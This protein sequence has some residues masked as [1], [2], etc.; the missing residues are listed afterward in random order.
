MDVF[1]HMHS[2]TLFPSICCTA[3]LPSVPPV[4]P[5]CFGVDADGSGWC[6]VLAD[7]LNNQNEVLKILSI[8]EDG[9][10]I[11]TRQLIQFNHYGEEYQAEV[12]LLSRR[13]LFTTD[14]A[15]L[16]G[17]GSI[18]KTVTKNTPLPVAICIVL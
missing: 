18:G 9:R 15:S 4:R 16:D 8:S 5:A 1:G 3:A 17:P 6:L 10:T 11:R 13:I 12:A 2:S 7:D 14:D